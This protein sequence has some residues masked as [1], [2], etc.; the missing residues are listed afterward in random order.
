VGDGQL[1]PLRDDAA[2]VVHCSNVLEHVRTPERLLAELT[3][4][5]EPGGI[6][7]LAFT[8]WL[9]P[10]GGHETSPWHYLG[11]ERALRR[12][13]RRTGRD[14]KN[15]YGTNLFPLHIPSVRSWFEANRRITVLW[16]GPRYWPPSWHWVG[17]AGAVGEAVSWN[18]LVIFRREPDHS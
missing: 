3:R 10:W 18:H 5:L 16:Q 6:G 2:Q 1:L 13:E 17:R 7:Y 14:A 4:V 8:P 12:Y 11:G 15:R 9:S